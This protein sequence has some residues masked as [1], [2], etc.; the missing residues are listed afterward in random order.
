MYVLRPGTGIREDSW[1]SVMEDPTQYH[2]IIFPVSK[3]WSR[4]VLW[5]SYCRSWPSKQQRTNKME[6]KL[7]Y[8]YTRRLYLPWD[9]QYS[10]EFYELQELQSLVVSKVKRLHTHSDCTRYYWARVWTHKWTEIDNLEHHRQC[11]FD[12]SFVVMD[13]QIIGWRFSESSKILAKF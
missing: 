13:F 11:T 5:S 8:N 9:S 6:N 3:W 10:I 4:T 1:W 7:D 12:S 2:S